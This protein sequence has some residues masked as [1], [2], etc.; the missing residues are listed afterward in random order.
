MLTW[1]LFSAVLLRFCLRSQQLSWLCGASDPT[2]LQRRRP[3]R[4][5]IPR[6]VAAFW[7]HYGRKLA[8]RWYGN[9]VV[10]TSAAGKSRWGVNGVSVY[11]SPRGALHR[12]LDEFHVDPGSDYGHVT[13][14]VEVWTHWLG[15]PWPT[16]EACAIRSCA[17]AHQR[18][19]VDVGAYRLLT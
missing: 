9:V 16:V 19:E 4:E 13:Q 6:L 11:S 8:L 3:P 7:W 10:G 18:G 14:G 5:W 12:D 15:P 1:Q 17:R 2:V